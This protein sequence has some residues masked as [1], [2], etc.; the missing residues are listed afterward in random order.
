MGSTKMADIIEY[1]YFIWQNTGMKEVLEPTVLTVGR[2][3]EHNH[4][5]ARSGQGLQW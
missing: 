2:G 3:C 1:R 4:T 5:K